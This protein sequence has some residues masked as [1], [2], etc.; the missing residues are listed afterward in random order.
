LN[1]ATLGFV[2]GLPTR[3]SEALWKVLG[4]TDDGRARE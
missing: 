3:D 4:L 1:E 2:S